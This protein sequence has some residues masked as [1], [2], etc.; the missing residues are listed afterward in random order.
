MKSAS[1]SWK[2]LGG[3]PQRSFV[4]DTPKDCVPC[5]DAGRVYVLRKGAVSQRWFAA[6]APCPYCQKGQDMHGTDRSKPCSW[7]KFV[8]ERC[9]ICG[10]YPTHATPA[11]WDGMPVALGR[12]LTLHECLHLNDGTAEDPVVKYTRAE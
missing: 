11:E 5:Q 8:G 7:A 9:V 6:V 4:P 2:R 3:I 10:A 1:V 12:V